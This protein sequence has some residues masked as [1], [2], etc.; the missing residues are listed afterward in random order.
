[1]I[2]NLE[3]HPQVQLHGKG[4]KIRSV[5]L[6]AETVDHY[7]RYMKQFYPDEPEYSDKPLFYTIRHHTRSQISKDTIEVFMNQYAKKAHATCNEVPE[8]IHPH[9]WRHSRA[10]HLYQ[11]GMDLTLISQWLGHSNLSTTLVY[12]YADTEMSFCTLELRVNNLC[13]IH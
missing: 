2:S 7:N 5:P 3:I 11:H 1:M 9:M 4:R 6:M 8:K 10:M 12:A 13:R